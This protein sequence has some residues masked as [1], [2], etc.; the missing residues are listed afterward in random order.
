MTISNSN[1]P[2]WQDHGF[3]SKACTNYMQNAGFPIELVKSLYPHR[4][5]LEEIPLYHW[6]YH[7]Q[8]GHFVK[9]RAD[10]LLHKKDG[11]MLLVVGTK[12]ARD[13]IG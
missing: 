7:Q 5:L 1:K 8:W 4:M 12:I 11:H 6:V 3:T 10:K 2:H 9:Q 13:Q